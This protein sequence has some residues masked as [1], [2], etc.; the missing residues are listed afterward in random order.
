MLL[1]WNCA[2]LLDHADCDCDENFILGEQELKKGFSVK[3]DQN[4]SLS[5]Q[6]D[7]YFKM[8]TLYIC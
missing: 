8:F 6:P 1:H 2:F 4:I 5:L 7:F 3:L